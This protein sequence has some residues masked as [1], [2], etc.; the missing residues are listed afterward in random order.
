[1]SGVAIRLSMHVPAADVKAFTDALKRY[2]KETK[3]D[4][5]GAIR[6]ATLDLVRSLRARTRKAPKVVP[7]ADVRWGESAPKY[8]TGTK[9]DARGVEFRRVVVTRWTHGARKN[10]VH[11]Q[12]VR[13]KMRQ[14]RGR[15]TVTESKAEMMR[16]A[17]EQ[18]GKIRQWGLAKKSWGW[19][20][21][22]LFQRSVPD[23]NPKARIRSGMVDKAMVERD[24]SMSITIVNK[25]E[26][27]RRALQPGALSSSLRAAAN[28]IN[29]K[30]TAGLRSRRFGA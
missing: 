26:Y 17:R 14:R 30:I 13:A 6:S 3:R 23:E 5:R 2:G 27:I 29:K 15:F 11:W 9:G 24:G 12:R 16:N 25:L 19:F 10:G 8:I 28:S 21:H 7:R 4:M 20:M 1:M 22:A 18:F